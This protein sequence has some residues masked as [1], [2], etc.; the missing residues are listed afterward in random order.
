MFIG[1]LWVTQSGTRKFRPS[2]T[3][4]HLA[5]LNCEKVVFQK[6]VFRISVSIWMYNVKYFKF[7]GIFKILQCHPIITDVLKYMPSKYISI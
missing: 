3:Q 7:G 2:A 4:C 6:C 5:S 1:G